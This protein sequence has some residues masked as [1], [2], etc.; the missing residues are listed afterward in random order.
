VEQATDFLTT[1]SDK[2]LAIDIPTSSYFQ[3]STSRARRRQNP[4]GPPTL[5]WPGH[6]ESMRWRVAGALV[7]KYRPS[8]G[9]GDIS[10]RCDG[11]TSTI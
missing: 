9:V 5:G 7:R 1:H 10:G 8:G 2:S 4:S 11:R 3:P 6:S